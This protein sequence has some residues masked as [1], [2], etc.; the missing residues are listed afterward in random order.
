MATLQFKDKQVETPDNESIQL[1]SQEADIPF[2]CRSGLCRTCEVIIDDGEE[3]LSKLNKLE[4]QVDLPPKH[5]LACQCVAK[6]G[7]IKLHSVFDE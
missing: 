4:E 3:N 5:R 1:A 2:G 7:I 6:K